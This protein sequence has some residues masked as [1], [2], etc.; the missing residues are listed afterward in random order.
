VKGRKE[1]TEAREFAGKRSCFDSALAGMD[2]A[3]RR[4]LGTTK[5]VYVR[6]FVGQ[7]NFDRIVFVLLKCPKQAEPRS[8]SAGA[9]VDYLFRAGLFEGR[10]QTADNRGVLVAH[11]QREL[12]RV[13]ERVANSFRTPGLILNLDELYP[14]HR[15]ASVP[16]RAR[17]RI[18]LWIPVW[19]SLPFR[20]SVLET[21][22]KQVYKEKKEGNV[23]SVSDFSRPVQSYRQPQRPKKDSGASVRMAKA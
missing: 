10:A 14:V 5:C 21:P 20:V 16:G 15:C 1:G 17:P 11:A 7:A 13:R 3:R 8:S 4:I 12:Q 9:Q 18:P 23:P 2:L 19:R 22:G 6:E